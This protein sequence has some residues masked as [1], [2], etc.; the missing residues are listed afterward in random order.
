MKS[1]GG[2]STGAAPDR[3][4]FRQRWQIAVVI[5]VLSA[6]AAVAASQALGSA[7]ADPF[8]P[9]GGERAPAFRLPTVE[10][11]ATDVSLEELKGRPVVLNFFASWCVPCRREL[12]ALQA[13]FE[14][15]A[16]DVTFMGIAHQDRREDA[17]AMLREAGVTY[18][19]GYDPRGEVARL[20][21]LYGMPTT[22]F[23]SADGVI[24]LR[25]TGELEAD[26]LE[27]A[28]DRLVAG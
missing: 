11:P 21:G 18:T 10:D 23:I 24:V 20:Y 25:R 13:A 5:G 14:R 26:D 3:R 19:S 1:D 17:R 9:G 16:G 8:A 28:I 6:L 4:W 12:P 2:T 27:R 7:D 15:H 22:V